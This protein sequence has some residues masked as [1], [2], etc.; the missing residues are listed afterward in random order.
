MTPEEK[1]A[2]RARIKE[3]LRTKIKEREAHMS[4]SDIFGATSESMKK[5]VED[6]L[7]EPIAG[8]VAGFVTGA[9]KVPANMVE[10]ALQLAD[11]VTGNK[12][13]LQYLNEETAQRRAKLDE[14]LKGH[15]ISGAVGE[16]AANLISLSL[17]HI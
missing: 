8:P 12:D 15:E 3:E 5:G 11:S 13:H 2:E 6:I 9:S 14:L 7:P 1:Q 17:I 16:T 4:M 10:G